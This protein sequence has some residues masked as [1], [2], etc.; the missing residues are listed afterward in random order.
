MW[1]PSSS[2]RV[3]CLS[4]GETLW[5]SLCECFLTISQQSSGLVEHGSV[6]RDRAHAVCTATRL[7]AAFHEMCRPSSPDRITC[8]SETLWS[9][10]CECFLTISQQ[11][12]G[13]VEH[14][15]VLW[16]RAH[17]VCTATRLVAACHEMWRP[18][19][20]G[21]VYLSVRDTVELSLRVFSDHISAVERSFRARIGAS[22][23][24]TCCLH[25]YKASGRL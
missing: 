13:L 8:L 3:T 1:R 12:S 4:A 10:L 19:S 11:W 18:S 9:S 24:C 23:P 7:M 21:R 14:G 6:R 16:D 5:S 20:S 25:S 15:S 22:G 17:A 2:G